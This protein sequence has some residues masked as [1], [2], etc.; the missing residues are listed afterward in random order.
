ME[1]RGNGE[2]K[3]YQRQKGGDGVHDEDRRQR[4]SGRRGQRE[5]V[6][7]GTDKLAVGAVADHG[8]M[9]VIAIAVS[10]D[11]EIDASEGGERDAA[12]DGG[13]ERGQE[14]QHKG[15]EE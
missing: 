2:G 8:P 1:V 14:Q 15:D 9:A 10:Q 5:L 6:V 13:G 7:G 4:V 12:N 11:A 3:A